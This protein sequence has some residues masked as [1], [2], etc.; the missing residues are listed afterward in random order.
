MV[1]LLWTHSGLLVLTL[2]CCEPAC[3]LG[4]C[5]RC[6]RYKTHL[7]RCPI[8]HTMTSPR[9]RCLE[10]E[11]LCRTGRVSQLPQ[12]LANS[13]LK[14][15]WHFSLCGGQNNGFLKTSAFLLPQT[16]DEVRLQWPSLYTAHF[17][18]G[19][20]VFFSYQCVGFLRIF[21]KWNFWKL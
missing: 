17:S 10:A 7:K 12:F 8:G 9:E 16:C 18:T 4:L 15:M 19:W 21:W 13:S 3:P 5:C 2:C 11:W 20:F 1:L 14:C 6:G